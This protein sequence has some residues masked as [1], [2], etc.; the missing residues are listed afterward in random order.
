MRKD[1]HMHPSVLRVPG[2]F[3]EFAGQ[4]LRRGIG[5][6]CITDH[7]PL[8]S[9]KGD[10]ILPGHVEEYRR[11]VLT[12]KEKW[13]GKLTVKLG[14]EV[15]YFPALTT[16]MAEVFD[17]GEY[18]WIHG[19][20]HLHVVRRDL[21]GT[22]CTFNEYANLSFENTLEA[23]QTGLFQSLSHIDIHRWAFSRQDR[24]P[25]VDDGYDVQ[26]HMSII[27]QILDAV[28]A[29]GM[30]LEINTHFAANTGD[31][32]NV[33]PEIPIVEL[34]LEKGVLFSF[35][36]DAHSADHVGI[37]LDELHAHPVYAKALETW[38]DD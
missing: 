5:E 22:E 30:R 19:S 13:A 35:G 11:E 18:D 28:K 37:L 32:E 12:I 27:S 14:I 16:E 1:Y 29:R 31:F 4:A 25:L 23:V 9:H 8:A 33:Y 15:D 17:A 10:R 38:E 20:T 24:F 26:R 2:G 3:D 34:A 21:F 36:S 6:V 7:M